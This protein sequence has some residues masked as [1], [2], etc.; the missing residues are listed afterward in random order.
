MFEKINPLKLSVVNASVVNILKNPSVEWEKITNTKTKL[1]YRKIN[2]DWKEYT[3]DNYLFT[4]CTICSSVQTDETGYRIVSPC[5]ELVNANGNAWTNAVLPNCFRTFI[6][7]YNFLNHMQVPE[8]SRGKIL[9]AVL[10]PVVHIG[11]NGKKAN[12][13]F[14]DILVATD[15][16]FFDL[17]EK[18][19][20]GKLN[21]LSMGGLAQYTQCSYC[22]KIIKDGEKPCIHIKNN[23]KQYLPDKD[24]NMWIVSELCGAIDPKTKEYIP[25]SFEFIEASWVDDPAFL[26][27]VLNYI[28]DSPVAK[29]DEFSVKKLESIWEEENLS[30]IKVADKP[31]NIALNVARKALT[32]LKRYK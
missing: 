5:D 23:L 32:D 22:G 18:I 31:F 4:H 13:F 9:D 28:I 27:A 10:R 30:K 7:G 3:T 29:N 20:S 16:M 25:N 11:K 17:I 8:L 26:G 24:G 14:C 6:G 12:I 19:E 1:A 15:R 2:V 21:T